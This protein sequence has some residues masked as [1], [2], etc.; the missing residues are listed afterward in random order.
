M[1]KK[2]GILAISLFTCSLVLGQAMYVV[3][4]EADINEEITL[5][6]NAAHPDCNCPNIRGSSDDMFFWSW[7]P[8]D[9]KVGNGQWTASNEQLKLTREGPDLYS[10]RFKP[11]EFYTINDVA[12]FYEEN[13]HGLI[14]KKD[15]GSGGSTD[16]ENK[17]A[18]LVA[19]I[20]PAPGCR[21]KFCGFPRVTQQDD[22]FTLIYDNVQEENPG[23]QNLQPGDV[24]L[25]PRAVADG[26]LVE[27]VPFEQV[28]NTPEL[29]MAYDGNGKFSLT[30]IPEEFFPIPPGAV[31]TAL[32]FVVR[33]KV[34]SSP[35]DKTDGIAVISVG[36]Q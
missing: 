16:V 21:A 8:S 6:I 32:T 25:F 14:K 24:Y 31:I 15:G 9:P 34:F 10:I 2:Y 19:E 13:I 35:A 20:D 5:Y 12:K 27:L 23:M 28:G 7:K 11:A 29:E 18:D 33:R 17:S 36:C 30:F 3:P 1:M 4:R 22:F 26:K